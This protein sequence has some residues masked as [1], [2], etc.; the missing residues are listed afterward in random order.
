M[1]ATVRSFIDWCRKDTAFVVMFVITVLG[2]G[3]TATGLQIQNS[4][5]AAWA[6]YSDS[7][8]D[9]LNEANQKL[10]D[11]MNLLTQASDEIDA[12][13]AEIINL[14]EE[15]EKLRDAS[16]LLD[17]VVSTQSRELR[18]R[19]RKLSDAESSEATAW[20]VVRNIEQAGGVDYRAGHCS[21]FQRFFFLYGKAL[22]DGSDSR[23]QWFNATG[24]GAR[25]RAVESDF[26]VEEWQAYNEHVLDTSL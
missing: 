16:D 13:D 11:N 19:D 9:Q 24:P 3:V 20:K 1:F 4:R 7:L 12:S 2:L 23:S 18:T 22:A 6:D 25:S 10:M 21:D 26:D 14:R 5:V 15:N 8:A 17:E